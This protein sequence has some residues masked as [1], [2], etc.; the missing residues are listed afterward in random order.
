MVALP[1][2]GAAMTA[3]ALI[4]PLAAAATA[5]PSPGS[6]N[7]AMAPQTAADE[8]GTLLAWSRHI[9]F[10][11]ATIRIV[12][13]RPGGGPVRELTDATGGAQDIDPKFSPDSTQVLF[14]RDLPDGTAQIV[15]VNVDGTNE[16]VLPLGCVDPCIFDVNPTWAPDGH[17]V[18]FT[19]VIGP[20]DPVTGAAASA[21]LWRARLDGGDLT[22]ISP[23]GIDGV[24]EEY[25]AS[26]APAGY[27][28]LRRFRN[29]DLTA[30]ALRR[31]PDG[32]TVQL[33]AYS[34]DVDKA[35]VSPAATGLSTGLVV[36]ETYG[37]GPPDGV[38]QAVATVPATCKG[39][40][41]CTRQT[42]YL[43]SPSS[44]PDQ[45]FNPAWAPDGRQ[46]AY[47]RFSVSSA[48][49]ETGDIWRMDWNGE[50]PR[51]V[52][53]SPLFDFRPAWGMLTTPRPS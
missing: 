37:E 41:Q 34:L 46:I 22:R 24:Y 32:R 39:P 31:D 47:V 9:T 27:M 28:V 18:Y 15:V 40:T 1:M 43:T 8:D 14:E 30:A 11:T 38:A 44:L 12:V 53:T 33:T 16:H 17:H 35:A 51:P 3:A 36:F 26:F 7:H 4:S 20:F 52:S 5:S 29:A 45:H 10:N 48:G 6:G 50:H 25:Q 13:G 2:L 21:V 42:R 23:P 49:F 19:R